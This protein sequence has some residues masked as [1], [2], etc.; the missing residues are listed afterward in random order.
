MIVYIRELAAA[1]VWFH[2]YFHFCGDK[3]QALAISE[4][5]EF[6]PGVNDIIKRPS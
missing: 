2:K 4:D 5:S 1:V 3:E 6:I